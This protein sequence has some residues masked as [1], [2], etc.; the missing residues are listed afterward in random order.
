M[1]PLPAAWSLTTL[2]PYFPRRALGNENF[3]MPRKLGGST[4][5][6][7]DPCRGCHL[8][9]D[10]VAMRLEAQRVTHAALKHLALKQRA[11]RDKHYF[12]AF[13]KFSKADLTCLLV[14][15][16]GSILSIVEVV[17]RSLQRL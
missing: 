3:V 6:R 7:L 2:R 15:P 14:M 17:R 9:T 13:R 4:G 10:L 5:A 12:F 11:Q 1:K 16:S 8:K